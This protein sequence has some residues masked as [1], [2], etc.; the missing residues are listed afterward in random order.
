MLFCIRGSVF[1][2]T[3]QLT[4][5]FWNDKVALKRD[6]DEERHKEEVTTLSHDVWTVSKTV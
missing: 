5:S 1:F 6:E 4:K 3:K 2:L